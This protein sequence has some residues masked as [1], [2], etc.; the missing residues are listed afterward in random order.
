M[1]VLMGSVVF[2][3]AMALRVAMIWRGRNRGCDAYYFL[4]CACEFRKTKRLPIIL[5]KVYVLE[6]REQWYPPGFSVL[7]SWIPQRVLDKYYW[8][9]SPMID[10]LIP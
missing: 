5:P 9:V 6:E 4:F 2:A 10:S 7:L 3:F 1:P 8:A